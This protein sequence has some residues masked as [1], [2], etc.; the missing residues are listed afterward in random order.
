VVRE[1][2]DPK[3]KK[4]DSPTALTSGAADQRRFMLA[5]LLASSQGTA[6]PTYGI[7]LQRTLAL[8]FCAQE[9]WIDVT[10]LV[11]NALPALP[12]AVAHLEADGDGQIGVTLVDPR[13]LTLGSL[14]SIA[15]GASSQHRLALALER[16]ELLLPKD[17]RI[18][19]LR[20]G[21][22]SDASVGELSLEI[23]L[24][25]E[26]AVSP[27]A[28]P[29]HSQRARAAI[30]GC[31]AEAGLPAAAISALEATGELGRASAA[32]SVYEAFI[33]ADPSPLAKRKKQRGRAG[34]I[35]RGTRG[36]EGEGAD[37]GAADPKTDATK[38]DT[39][40]TE[41][42]YLRVEGREALMAGARRAAHHVVH[43]LKA[44]R[45]AAADWFRNSDTSGHGDAASEGGAA[46]AVDGASD[47]QRVAVTLVLDNVRS[48][49]NV[50]SIFR[51]ADTAC[52]AEV[53]TCGFTPH[54]PH[55]KLEKTGFSTMS[56]VPT[57]HFGSTMAA[58]SAL[59]AEGVVH[60]AAMET[61]A[62]SENYVAT[63]F[64]R[65][66]V[67]IVLGNEEVGVDIAVLDECD[68]IIE[69]PTLGTKNS[70]NVACAA[71]VVVFEVLRKWGALER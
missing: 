71:S 67:A 32:Q 56:A 25:T 19:A 52:L 30:H 59:R 48:A 4:T 1:V 28:L 17:V 22:V 14:A 45:V 51:T 68:C 12:C 53:I 7:A 34:S 36:A 58:L 70:L 35:P 47:R 69:I 5:V 64:P 3:N 23:E 41:E 8:N 46:V 16:G 60:V 29:A 57:R 33:R 49:Y 44:E 39:S 26:L 61:T 27:G 63:E 40:P 15:P 2:D 18:L 66:G 13:L 9:E 43:L 62:R 24:A 31:L 20:A 55:P 50:G 6:F 37:R 21:D 11:T 65:S 42:A 54:P 38:P 10:P